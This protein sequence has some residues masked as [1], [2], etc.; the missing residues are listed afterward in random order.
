[1]KGVAMIMIRIM[2][3]LPTRFNGVTQEVVRCLLSMRLWHR[4][5]LHDI[6]S[7]R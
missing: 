5:S 4:I 2:G 7:G 6:V 3:K 1:V